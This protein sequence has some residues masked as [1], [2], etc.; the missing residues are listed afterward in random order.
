MCDLHAVTWKAV[1]HEQVT[2]QTVTREDRWAVTSHTHAEKQK[3]EKEQ[4]QAEKMQHKE[5]R[6]I[7]D[8]HNSLTHTFFTHILV[9]IPTVLSFSKR[10]SSLKA[11]LLQIG[12]NS[13]CH[14]Q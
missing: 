14:F 5:T 1:A 12:P 11:D 13:H 8:T 9:S 2:E 3:R 6:Q 7:W 4:K 10:R